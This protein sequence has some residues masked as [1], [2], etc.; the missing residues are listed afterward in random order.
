MISTSDYIIKEL[1]RYK[2]YWQYIL[3][4]KIHLDFVDGEIKII[5]ARSPGGYVVLS[6]QSMNRPEVLD[7]LTIEKKRRVWNKIRRIEYWLKQLSLR[8]REVIFWRYIQHDFEPAGVIQETNLGLKWKTLSWEEIAQ[9]LH[10]NVATVREYAN[11]ALEK[12]TNFTENA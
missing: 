9:K 10:L 8:E 7:R 4:K 6:K 2:S 11:R 3:D 12:L 5:L 1:Q